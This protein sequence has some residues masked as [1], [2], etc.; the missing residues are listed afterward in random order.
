MRARFIAAA[1]AVI[2][3]IACSRSEGPARRIQGGNI[4]IETPEYTGVIFS[5]D[6]ASEWGFLFGQASTTFWEPSVDEISRA[7]ASMR[8]FLLAAEDNSDLRD[9]QK[10]DAAFVL[11]NL[12][13]YRRQYVGIEVDGEKRI[14]CN[15]FRE[16]IPTRDWERDPVYVLDGGRDYWDIT[17]IPLTDECTRFSVHGAS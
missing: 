3:L 11:E 13:R 12:A 7:E 15:L 9:Y 10:A 14:W 8:Q 16:D 17:Y 6:T 2:S 4:L 1:I 5:R